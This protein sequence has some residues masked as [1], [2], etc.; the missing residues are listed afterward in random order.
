MKEAVI[1]LEIS[2]QVKLFYLSIN[3]I[4]LYFLD[5]KVTELTLV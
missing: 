1:F 5:P 3:N 2:D 4:F